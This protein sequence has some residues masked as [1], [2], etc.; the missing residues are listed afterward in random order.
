MWLTTAGLTFVWFSWEEKGRQT[1]TGTRKEAEKERVSDR[2]KNI[3]YM[4][5]ET[6]WIEGNRG[7]LGRRSARIGIRYKHNYVM[8]SCIHT[9]IGPIGDTYNTA[10]VFSVNIGIYI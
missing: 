4:D 2:Q 5:K 1:E 6:R 10:N 9:M 3:F 7:M 8:Y